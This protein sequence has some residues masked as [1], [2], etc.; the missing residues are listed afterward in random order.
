MIS[1]LA[2]HLQIWGFEED[3]IIYT[4][5]SL[6]F[7]LEATPVDVSTWSDERLNDLSINI[8]QFLNGLSPNIDIQF[9]QDILPG[10]QKVIEHH[11]LLGSESH[12]EV[13]KSLCNER[14]QLLRKDDEL[15]FLP[16]H[17]LKV[18]VRKPLSSS[19][20]S[21]PKLFSKENNFQ[22]I[23]EA[24]LKSEIDSLLRL[25]DN[26]VQG[27][28]LLGVTCRSF[29]SD[30]IASILYKQ[31][32][33]SRRIPFQSYD[34]EEVRQTLLY[35]DVAISLA[36]F[37]IGQTQFRVISLKQLPEQTYS[38]MASQLRELPFK[39]RLYT[40]I[41]VPD[42]MK[43]IQNLQTQRRIAYS[44]AV[45]K[46]TGVSDIESSAKFQ[47]LETLLEQMIA[48]GQ[49]VFHVST[50]V[51]LQSEDETDLENQVDLTLSKFR[52]MGGAEGLT[53]SLASFD[54]FAQVA[55]PNSRCKERVK[56]IKTSNLCDL[57]PI[58]GPWPGHKK[59]SIILKSRMGNILSFDPFDPSLSNFNSLVSGASGSGK[60]AMTNL[61]LMQML[62]E[63]VKVFFCD[64]GGSYKKLTENLSG[65]YVELGTNDHLAVNP[66]DLLPGESL[67]SPQKIKFLLGLVELMTR[68]DGSERIPK[69]ARSEIE[70]AIQ[71]VYDTQKSPT[72]S[73]LRTLLLEHPEKEIKNY[74]RILSTWCGDTPYGRFIDK[75][76]NVEFQKDI[77]AFDLKGLENY[78]DLQG[79]C[80]YIITDLVWREV[81]KDRSR[82]KFIVFDECWRLLRDDAAILF[83][84]EVFRT[85]R[86]YYCSAIAISQDLSDFLNS[87]I[88]S[89]LLPNCTIKW[90]LTQNQSDFSKMKESLGLNDNEIS[91]IQS[92]HQKKGEYAEA[93]L[94]AGAERRTVAVIE[95]TPLELWIATTDP[96][97]LAEIEQFKKTEPQLSQLEILKHLANKFPRGVAA[98]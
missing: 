9:V 27:L 90:I 5:G 60:S 64:V 73:H 24:R 78:P 16:T 32:N 46:R 54:I 29:T 23:S 7:A 38:S 51:L 72:L 14:A 47:D 95:P 88:S 35:S 43:E 66:F 59:P 42:Q 58:Y 21:T 50:T 96:R 86:K 76:T 55:L 26:I 37:A 25:R 40:T 67:P 79:V 97:D 83:I 31:W 28:T 15:G 20:I 19:L 3:A 84:E 85:V 4:D 39:S 94:V 48:Q 12:N 68:E 89:A 65:Q 49:K 75:P 93:F 45:G 13:A 87:K 30:E 17:Q 41:H 77:V 63:N 92:L 61:L 70:S 2:D 53:E 8:Q 80:L 18:I 69:L 36:G 56:K 22:E 11:L 6:G 71:K 57:L 74:G 33:P 52:E 10:N 1:A 62:K 81:Q 91:L 82:K 34:P 44:M 98:S